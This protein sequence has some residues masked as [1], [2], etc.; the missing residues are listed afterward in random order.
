MQFYMPVKVYEEENCVINH[1]KELAQCGKK[2]LIMTGKH[3]AKKNGALA[4][5]CTALEAEGISWILFDE[6]E[7]NP[8]VETVM[9]ARETGWSG[10]ADFVIGIGG[11]SAM[12]AAK[13]AALMMRHGEK[14]ASY[15]Y[16]KGEDSASL[17]V[18]AVPS[19]CGTGSEVT[20][21]SVLTRRDKGTKGSIP[22]RI[23]PALAL[24]DAKYLEAAPK[25][26]LCNTAVD[27]FAHLAESY[28]NSNATA[29]S[30]MCV[31]AGLQMWKKTRDVLAGN[32]EPEKEDYRNLLN[33]S[34]MAGMAICH[35]GTSLP[36]GLSYPLTCELNL[37]HGVAVGYFLGGYL[38]EADEAD[39][40]Y[41]LETAGFSSVDEFERF[42]DKVCHY[43]EIPESLLQR[44]MEDILKNEAK[45]KNCPYPADEKVLRRIAKISSL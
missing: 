18:V 28:I 21:V 40:R 22:H 2:A 37:P 30:R 29:Y 23:F 15:L 41:V 5:V 35:T 26:V 38:R 4:D 44:T 16:E 12:D 33:A 7:E 1:K 17:P 36:H 24:L 20:A 45:L 10:Q 34:M 19:T 13:A 39:S 42:F 11:G 31:A 27:A 3:S 8:S 25:T 9:R 14:D 6:V 32:R 43:G